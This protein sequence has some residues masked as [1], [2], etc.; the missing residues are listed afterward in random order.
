[1]LFLSRLTIAQ[2]FSCEIW[3]NG[4]VFL[5]TGDTLFVRLM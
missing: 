4:K 2:E 3:H 5:K 1:M